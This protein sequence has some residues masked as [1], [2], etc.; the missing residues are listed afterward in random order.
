MDGTWL[1]E[2]LPRETGKHVLHVTVAGKPITV[3]TCCENFG[4][5]VV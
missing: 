3:C 5:E 4:Y 2:I 1:L